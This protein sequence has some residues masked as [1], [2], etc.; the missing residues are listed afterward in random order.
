[1]QRRKGRIHFFKEVGT[2]K[3]YDIATPYGYGGPVFFPPPPES[4]SKLVAGFRKKFELY[5]RKNKGFLALFSQ[6]MFFRKISVRVNLSL[7]SKK[8]GKSMYRK[9][10]KRI[11]DITLALTILFLFC[12]LFIAVAFIVKIRLG[13]PVIFRQ[14]RPG[15]DGKIFT[16]YK[17][18]SLTEEKDSSGIILPSKD[19]LTDFGRLLRSTSLDELPEIWNVLKG[20]MTFIGPRPLL[21][22][23]LIRYN[24]FQFRRHEVKPGITGWAQVNGRNAIS[25]KKKFQLDIE[26]VDNCNFFLDM[27]IIL[28]TIKKVFLRDGISPENSSFTR[29]FMGNN[30]E[31][32]RSNDED[33]DLTNE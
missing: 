28:L 24:E 15:K 22:K 6:E 20:D 7:F 2:E 19:R 14:E 21:V 4:L 17:F 27:K 13:T 29:E 1:V 30:A 23:Y 26:Y 25:W 9:Y 32:L 16:M 18:R 12:W 33:Q 11:L 8:G 31:G 3:Y 10:F 5:C